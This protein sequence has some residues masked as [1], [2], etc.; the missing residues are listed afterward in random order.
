MKHYLLG[1]FLL[2]SFLQSAQANVL[3]KKG[4]WTVYYG[5]NRATYTKGDYHLTGNGY[6]FTLKN[7]SAHDRQSDL[8][9]DPYAD[10][11]AWS[12]PQ[13]NIRFS[14]FLTDTLAISF[15][16]DHMKYV[17]D[18]N[19]IV[20]FQGSINTGESGGAYDRSGNQKVNTDQ[21]LTFE[22]TDG[23]NFVSVEMEQFKP[24]WLSTKGTHA[25]SL[26]WGPG[27]AIM[28]P[29]TNSKLFGRARNDDF[30]ISGTGYSVKVGVEYIFNRWFTRLATK[31]GHINMDR[32]WTTSSSSDRLS[33]KFDFTQTFLVIG[34]YF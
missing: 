16:N 12:V 15:G 17:M 19:Q 13:N 18:S 9:A 25:F 22:H 26:F 4:K 7:V 27:L 24:L 32:A 33:H 29:K 2:V 34:L 10:P 21:I 28:Y 14:Y 30:H 31:V 1:I 3:E 8:G 5:Y 23:L 20:D 11:F 6:D